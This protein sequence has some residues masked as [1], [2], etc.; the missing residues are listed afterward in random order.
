M[1]KN[2]ENQLS[3]QK[4]NDSGRII[5]NRLLL[6]NDPIITDEE[7]FTLDILSILSDKNRKNILY[8]L[9]DNSK[10]VKEI[11]MDLDISQSTLSSH[12][13][14]LL[15]YGIIKVKTTGRRRYYWI[16]EPNIFHVYE[17]LNDDLLSS[18]KKNIRYNRLKQAIR[19]HDI[20]S[21]IQSK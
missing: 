12:L 15:D 16:S 20:E 2:N 9:R 11:Q 5:L 8:I 13:K 14:V 1:L 3:K 19:N 18:L 21:L 7:G 6:E 17:C 4:E 10:C